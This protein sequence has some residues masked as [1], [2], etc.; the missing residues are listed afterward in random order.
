MTETANIEAAGP[1]DPDVATAQRAVAGL[2]RVFVVAVLLLAAMGITVAALLGLQRRTQEAVL[3]GREVS[4]LGR[5]VL[6]LAVD[7]ETALRGFLLSGDSAALA[8]ERAAQARLAPAVDSLLALTATSPSQHLRAKGVS[9]A[10][11]RWEGHYRAPLFAELAAGGLPHPSREAEGRRLFDGLRL[12]VGRFIDA[13]EVSYREHVRRDRRLHLVALVAVAIE[14]MALLLV[15]VQLRA[16]LI[17]Q[18]NVLLG[19]RAALA[20]QAGELTRSLAE[21]HRTLVAV[22]VSEARYRALAEAAIDAVITVDAS[23]RIVYWNRAATRIFG[24]DEAEVRGQPLAVVVPAAATSAPRFAGR[25]VELDGRRR[26]GVSFPLE[27]SVSRWEADGAE[28]FTAVVRD[29]SERR[30][31]EAALRASEARYRLLVERSPEAIVLHR[32]GILLYINHTGARLLGT[33]PSSVVGRSL[34]QF[35][36]PAQHVRLME[37]LGAIARGDF[38]DQDAEYRV[39]RADGRI[40][41]VEARSVPIV[42][43]GEP[44]VQ[45]VVR[46]VTARHAAEQ[47][48]RE[49][50]ERLRIALDAARMHAWQHD[51][52]CRGEGHQ[53]VTGCV[54]CLMAEVSDTIH[55]DDRE[56]VAA[57]CRRAVESRGDF[58]VEFRATGADRSAGAADPGWRYA[59]GR[60]VLDDE[61]RPLRIIGVSVDV[62]E[63]KRLEAALTRQAF[64]D[65]LTGL[66]NRALFRQRVARALLRAADAPP[67]RVPGVAVLFLD[68]D[69]FKG[70]NDGLGHAAGDRLLAIVAARLRDCVGAGDT[71]ARLGGDE[72]ALLVERARDADDVARLADAVR[73]TLRTPVSLEGREVAVTASIGI[74]FAARGDTVDA[75]LGNADLA[76]YRAKGSG[77]GQV[78]YFEPAMHVAVMERLALEADL[79][80]ALERGELHVVYQPVV[81]LDSGRPVGVETLLRWSHPVRGAVPPSVFVPIAEEMGLIESLGRWVL[82]EACRQ[83]V[84]WQGHAPPSPAASGFAVGVNLSGRQLQRPGFV[85]DVAA[86]L[87]ESGLPPGCLVLE[88]T[89]SVL[90]RDTAAT[91]AALR[92]LKALGVR[93]AVDDFGTGYSSLQYLQRFPIDVL[94]IDRA[95]VDHVARG[96]NDAALMRTILALGDTM[97]LR[98]VAEG[99]E[100]EEQ[101]VTLQQLGCVLG[102]GY[103][104]AYPLPA[105]EVSALLAAGSAV[106]V[107]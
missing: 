56:R 13:E 79:R 6:A 69:D 24:Y 62:T 84:A 45:T 72:F 67:E 20:A 52:V 58:E 50:E 33:D 80:T 49:S 76:M 1:P 93:L 99:V 41:R 83:G 12:A 70:V 44:A 95:F 60:V 22:R 100:T 86:A 37:T 17:A 65:A 32:G 91:L 68:L 101:R 42:Y 40:A 28:F 74:V 38:R 78:A 98:T 4:R 15:L 75:L 57:A 35:V 43:D 89:E 106:A 51:L 5:A 66:A 11:A 27:L 10:V 64:H 94:K 16:R 88:I 92:A 18:A 19:Q 14:A 82:R 77:K 90:M 61:A 23:R 46:D 2:S 87:A 102:Q 63:R 97:A 39:V 85:A 34:A 3:H 30:A 26:D 31:T 21:E 25:I 71:V 7:R 73:E 96:G 104:F 9:A 105:D 48:V 107:A 54:E 8:P 103:L 53:R 55:P 59:K 29:A 47:A 81:E 36:D